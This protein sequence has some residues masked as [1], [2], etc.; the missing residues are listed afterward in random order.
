MK[1]SKIL[2]AIAIGSMITV[3]SCKDANTKTDT[4]QEQV[5]D[6]IRKKKLVI[7]KNLMSMEHQKIK[8][9]IV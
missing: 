2:F 5:V 8:Q 9:K 6:E 3:T 7:K 4:T 1:I